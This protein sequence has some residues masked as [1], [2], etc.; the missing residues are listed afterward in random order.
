MEQGQHLP[1]LFPGPIEKGSPLFQNSKGNKHHQGFWEGVNYPILKILDEIGLLC[2]FKPKKLPFS[3]DP[4]KSRGRDAVTANNRSSSYPSP[5]VATNKWFSILFQ[6]Y[7][8]LSTVFL[9]PNHDAIRINNND[10]F[11]TIKNMFKIYFFFW[12]VSKW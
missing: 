12:L 4:R 11:S 3:I 9:S 1:L 6:N 5:L 10:L 7:L 8:S 2:Y